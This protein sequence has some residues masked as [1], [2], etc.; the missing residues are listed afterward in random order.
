MGVLILAQC[1]LDGEPQSN[2]FRRD[3]AQKL[4][5]PYRADS[6]VVAG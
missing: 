1:H 4:L 6:G 3:T 2:L 5:F